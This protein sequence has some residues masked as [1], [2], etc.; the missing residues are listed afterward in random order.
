VLALMIRWQ[1]AVPDNDFLSPA[2]Y[3]QVFTMH[4]TTMMFLF[5]VPAIEAVAVY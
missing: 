2:I 3:N 1:L 4:G 5:A